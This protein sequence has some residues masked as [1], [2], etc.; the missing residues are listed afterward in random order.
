MPEL[1]I[2]LWALVIGAL[3]AANAAKVDAIARRPNPPPNRHW[4]PAIGLGLAAF[5]AAALA[6]GST[7]ALSV[8]LII[9]GTHLLIGERALRRLHSAL[10]RPG[11]P[12]PETLPQGPQ[13]PPRRPPPPL[14]PR[15]RLDRQQPPEEPEGHGQN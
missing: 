9:S 11:Q 5:A 7:A 3:I 12:S 13:P 8:A 2:L 10:G 4:I 15:P 14:P 1:E 6:I